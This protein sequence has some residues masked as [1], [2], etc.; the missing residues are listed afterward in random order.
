MARAL[1]IGDQHDPSA[2]RRD[3]LHVRGGLLEQRVV[4]REHDHGDV[5]V[6]ERDGPVLELARSVAL[7]VDVGDFLELQR[8]LE[9]DG[10][11]RPAAEIEHVERLREGLRQ[12]LDL[13]LET[14]RLGHQPRQLDQR[15]HKLGFILLRQNLPVAA[16]LDGERRQ[17]RELAGERLGGRDPDLD[18]G[19]GRKHDVGLPGDRRGRHVDDRA[20]LHAL[21]AAMAERRERVRRLAGL[22][23]HQRQTARRQR[24]LAV[25]KLRGDVDV[26]RKPSEF[27][28][29]VAGHEAG[30]IGGAAGRDRQPV[31]AGEVEIAARRQPHPAR[32]HVDEPDQRVADDLRLLRDLFRHEVAVSALVDD[33][34]GDRG[35]HRLALD[36]RP[37]LVEDLHA[38]AR[39]GDPVAI[40]QIGDLVGERSERHRVRAEIDLAVA[41]AERERAAAPGADQKI[42]LPGEQEGERERPA[43]PFQRLLDGE[44][45]GRS[46]GQRVAHQVS[47]HLGVGL[48]RERRALRRQFVAELAKILDDAVM[49]DGDGLG[50][51]RMRVGFGRGAVRRPPRVA[52]PRTSGQRRRGERRLQVPQLA[53]GP[54]PDDAA[55]IEGRHAGGV[56]AAILEPLQPFD[57]L[58]GHGIT[59]QN[60]NDAAHAAQFSR[61]SR[62][63]PIARECLAPAEGAS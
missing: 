36:Q 17:H 9:R 47:D 25:A 41:M 31:E 30:V 7:G 57:E 50:R 4:G 44:P 63:T 38:V 29:P 53:L 8:A 46:G 14:Q 32:G 35:P 22:R 12:L 3:L 39:Q 21:G 10:I 62:R 55:M 15:R 6:D 16:R 27:L 26:D 56:V 37:G 11:A 43:Q 20:D 58:R 51:M 24:R 42:V 28:E 13:R 1:P 61:S 52:D 34:R 60:A 19:D 23:D 59:R 54:A 49:D 33:H 48:A 2:A 18:A 40:L 45:R 5:L